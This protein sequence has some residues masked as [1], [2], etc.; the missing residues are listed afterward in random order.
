M[1]ITSSPSEDHTYSAEPAKGSVKSEP[2]S[3]DEAFAEGSDSDSR[4]V[5]SLSPPPYPLPFELS[6]G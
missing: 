3:P 6:T 1:L 4:Y 5:L 2:T